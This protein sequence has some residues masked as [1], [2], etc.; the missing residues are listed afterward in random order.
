MRLEEEPQN[1]SSLAVVRVRGLEVIR[2]SF[3]RE[4]RV[5]MGNALLSGA[6]GAHTW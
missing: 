4:H 1:L 2:L 5:R 3:D 6:L